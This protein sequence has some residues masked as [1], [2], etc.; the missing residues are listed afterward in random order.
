MPSTQPLRHIDQVFLDAE[1]L[2]RRVGI[3]NLKPDGKAT[4]LAFELPDMSVTRERCAGAEEARK[5]F[6]PEEWGVVSL[7][8]GDLPPREV[9]LHHS[10]SYFF[11]ARHVPEVGVFAHSEVRIWREDGEDQV[12]VTNRPLD[13]CSPD[14]PDR[15]IPRTAPAA[16]DPQFH[17][18]WR[19]RIE[20]RCKPE[21]KPDTAA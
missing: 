16:L 10:H 4:F 11:R 6:R 17:M 19:K 5:G 12:L 7:L 15:E 9:V 21:L 18:K 13:K 8:A 14:D 2:F 1:R 20:W 3:Q